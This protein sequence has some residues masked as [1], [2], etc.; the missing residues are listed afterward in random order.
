MLFFC[1]VVISIN[2]TQHVR[3]T[4]FV[5]SDKMVLLGYNRSDIVRAVEDNQCN[6]T[7]ATYLLLQQQYMVSAV[8][9]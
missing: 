4:V 5:L 2:S 7:M 3:C 1:H 8:L 9:C 6:E